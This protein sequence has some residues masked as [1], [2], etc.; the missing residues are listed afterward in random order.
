MLG[1]VTEQLH[2]EQSTGRA[3]AQAEAEQNGLFG[4]PCAFFGFSFV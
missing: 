2:T 1:F 4:A 3:A